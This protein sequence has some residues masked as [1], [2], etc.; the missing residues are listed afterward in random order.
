MAHQSISARLMST[1]EAEL[2]EEDRPAA[3]LTALRTVYDDAGR[4]VELGQHVYRASHY[5][6]EVSLV[7]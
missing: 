5:S 1:E 2:L 3:C 7:P 6:M 4:F